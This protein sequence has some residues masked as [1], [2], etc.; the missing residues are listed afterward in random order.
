VDEK[1]EEK[2]ELGSVARQEGGCRGEATSRAGARY[3][4]SVA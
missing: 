3:T 1:L 4:D 2:L